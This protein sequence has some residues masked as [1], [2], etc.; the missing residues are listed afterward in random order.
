MSIRVVVASST[1]IIEYMSLY[2]SPHN[3]QANPI[4]ARGV[5]KIGEFGDACGDSEYLNFKKKVIIFR[6]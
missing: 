1:L 4:L 2:P 6:A 5:R 3:K